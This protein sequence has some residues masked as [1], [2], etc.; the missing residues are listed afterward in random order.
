VQAAADYDTIYAYLRR[1]HYLP[2]SGTW[3]ATALRQ[4]ATTTFASATK[5]VTIVGTASEAGGSAS[6]Q[7]KFSKMVLLQAIEALLQAECADSLPPAEP[8]GV[9]VN[10]GNRAAQF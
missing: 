10:F 7:M 2:A 8:T 6:G 5:E 9:I 3:N 4:L 1:T